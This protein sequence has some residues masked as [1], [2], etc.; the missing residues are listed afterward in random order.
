MRWSRGG[1][2]QAFPVPLFSAPGSCAIQRRLNASTH[3]LDAG[4]W[5]TLQCMALLL[6]TVA[7]RRTC[8]PERGGHCQLGREAGPQGDRHAC[9]ECRVQSQGG[10][11]ALCTC[12]CPQSPQLQRAL[13]FGCGLSNQTGRNQHIHVY[14]CLQRFAAVIMRIREPKTTALIFASGKMVR[15][16]V[17]WLGPAHTALVSCEPMVYRAWPAAQTQAVAGTAV[18]G[19]ACCCVRARSCGQRWGGRAGSLH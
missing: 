1:V 4:V 9:Q 18:V 2:A 8:P 17:L 6:C 10:D 15:M 11:A 5:C 16:P 12:C 14:F 3:L 13:L 19:V 7:Q